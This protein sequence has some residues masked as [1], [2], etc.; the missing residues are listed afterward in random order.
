[1]TRSVRE[2]LF[3]PSNHLTRALGLSIAVGIAF[4]LAARFGLALRTQVGAAVFWP[5]AGIAV[6]ALVVVERHARLAIAAAIAI[7]TI[8]ASLTIGRSPWL[9]IAFGLINAGQA[10][11]TAYL[12]E[13]WFNRPFA[14]DGVR[15]VLGFVAATALGAAASAVAG[16]AAMTLPHTT[17]PFWEVWRAWFLSGAVGTVVVAPFLIGLAQLWGE[18]PSKGEWIEGAGVLALLVLTSLYTVTS[19]P[20]VWVTFSPGALVLPF[21]LWLAARCHPTFGI[22]GAFVASAAVLLGTTFGVGRFGDASVAITERVAGAQ[23]AMTVVTLYTLV[24]T[25]LFTERRRNEVALKRAA[26]HQRMLVAELSHRVKNVLATVAAI[27]SRTQDANLSAADFTT[28]LAGRI[29][30]MAATHELI[31]LQDW[32][33]ISVRELVQLELAPY[34][35]K[36]NADLDGPDLTLSP[37]AGQALSMVLHELATNAAKHGALATDDGRVSV[38]WNRA[39]NGNA[40]LRIEWQESGGPAVQPFRRSGFGLEVIRNLVPYE[41]GGSVD[42]VFAQEG[43][44]CAIII[45]LT[46]VS[47]NDGDGNRASAGEQWHLRLNEGRHE[48]AKAV[49]TDA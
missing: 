38:R 47:S 45:P 5:A 20:G 29:Q 18:Q 25:A 15:P 44:R 34:M 9:A 36:D 27:A 17:A 21:L 40:C 49:T 23:A 7:A 33:G 16:A 12:I 41:L 4:F 26:E 24:L 6:A 28:T 3:P 2:A 14:F 31:S 42:L 46:E 30:A 11:L 19:P 1:M 22:A 32:N 35:A 43:L 8:A 48:A 37:A 13:R 39:Q 10:L